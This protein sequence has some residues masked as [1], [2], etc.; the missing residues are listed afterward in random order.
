M[1]FQD[2][3]KF[4]RTLPQFKVIPLSD[5]RAVAYATK[6]VSEPDPDSHILGKNGNIFL[7][8]TSY[9]I[10]KIIREYPDLASKLLNH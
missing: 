6:E 8:I 3:V 4:L 1:Q 7:T 5:V 9:D 10:E 2:K